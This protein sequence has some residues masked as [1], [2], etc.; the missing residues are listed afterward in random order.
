[1]N[2]T[3]IE[4]TAGQDKYEKFFAG[5]N[6]I[7]WERLSYSERSRWELKAKIAFE[8]ITEHHIAFARAVVELA[9]Q[10]KMTSISL[11]FQQSFGVNRSPHE[12]RMQWTPGRHNCEDNIKLTCDFSEYVEERIKG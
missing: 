10:H 6:P 5:K 9:R 1:M 8:A 2:E 3:V 7:P 12:V 11:A 4:K